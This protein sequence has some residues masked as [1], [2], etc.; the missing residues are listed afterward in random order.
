MHGAG[1]GKGVV[2]V[3]C[4]SAGCWQ[5]LPLMQRTRYR[6]GVL[7]DTILCARRCQLLL[8]HGASKAGCGEGHRPVCKI[9]LQQQ[10]LHMMQD[11]I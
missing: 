1:Y 2:R 11:M 10:L 7:R 4:L 9:A 8:L 5:L 6:E 3:T